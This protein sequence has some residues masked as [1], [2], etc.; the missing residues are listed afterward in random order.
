MREGGGI[1]VD[2]AQSNFSS[3]SCY[4]TEN[5][6]CQIRR[7]W[8]VINQF[9]ATV[10]HSSH[11]KHRLVCMSTVLVKQDS[12]HQFSRPFRNVSSTTFQSPELLSLSQFW[13]MKETMQLISGKVEFNAC[14]VSLLWHNSLVTT[15][16]LPFKWYLA[17]CIIV[18]AKKKNVMQYHDQNWK[19]SHIFVLFSI[20]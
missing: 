13:F 15:W 5:R 11:C 9:K 20:F 16:L 17:H 14:Q 12:P 3:F 1:P 7:I 2:C 19:K 6:W 18:S 8:R 4:G 10:M